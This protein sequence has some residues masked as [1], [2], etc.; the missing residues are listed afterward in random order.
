MTTPL[1]SHRQ[2][3]YAGAGFSSD[4]FP[5]TDRLQEEIL[6]VPMGPA[7]TTEDVAYVGRACR[8]FFGGAAL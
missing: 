7:L 2:A 1:A 3:A 6:S 4:D 8:A 5:V